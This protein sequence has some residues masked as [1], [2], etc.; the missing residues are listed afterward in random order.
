LA[1]E[2]FKPEECECTDQLLC[3]NGA[4]REQFCSGNDDG[5]EL[6]QMGRER[7]PYPELK[8]R[9]LTNGRERTAVEIAGGSP[10]LSRAST[11]LTR[12]TPGVRLTVLKQSLDGPAEVESL[13]RLKSRLEGAVKIT[14]GELQKSVFK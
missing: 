9:V 11:E 12:T 3:C 10:G 13:R 2:S 1:G 6:G 14:E 4:A 7:G 5:E 8:A